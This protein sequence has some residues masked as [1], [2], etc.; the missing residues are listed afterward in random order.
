MSLEPEVIHCSVVGNQV[1]SLIA[2][3]SGRVS[4]Y[5]VSPLN[6]TYIQHLPVGNRAGDTRHEGR[7]E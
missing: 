1:A 4:V 2:I 7:G 3:T 6:S 5:K